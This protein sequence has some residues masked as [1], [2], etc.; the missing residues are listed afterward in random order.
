MFVLGWMW[1]LYLVLVRPC[2]SFVLSSF[3]FSLSNYLFFHIESPRDYLDLYAYNLWFWNY[4]LRNSLPHFYFSC[5][6]IGEYKTLSSRSRFLDYSF[7]HLR[8]TLDSILRVFEKR[9]LTTRCEY[10]LKKK[11]RLSI[12]YKIQFKWWMDDTVWLDFIPV[13]KQCEATKPLAMT[14]ICSYLV[15]S[16]RNLWHIQVWPYLY[17]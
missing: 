11:S 17:S 6:L 5:V 12:T 3:N 7:C 13:L 1:S 2:S 15:T 14:I 4:H 10:I 9:T 16:L 8:L